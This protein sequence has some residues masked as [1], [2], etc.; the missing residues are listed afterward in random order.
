MKTW[1]TRKNTEKG[2]M[3]KNIETWSN[4]KNT[5]KTVNVFQKKHDKHKKMKRH[6]N[7][8]SKMKKEEETF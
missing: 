6:E 5:M 8:K 4:K 3:E 2:K 7:L 1:K